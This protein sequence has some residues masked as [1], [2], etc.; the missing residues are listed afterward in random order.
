MQRY[1]LLVSFFTKSLRTEYKSEYKW[2]QQI[3]DVSFVQSYSGL[4]YNEEN[5]AT[6]SHLL[7]FNTVW[8][9]S[10]A[11]I[12]ISHL[13]FHGYID[14]KLNSFRVFVNCSPLDNSL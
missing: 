2:I 12:E 6:N 9:R 10:N 14:Q 3:L 7:A 8:C 11:R 1:G 4:R 13:R 5:F